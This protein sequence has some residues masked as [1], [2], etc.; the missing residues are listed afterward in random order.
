MSSNHYLKTLSL[1]N[2]DMNDSRIHHV[3]DA[4][5]ENR[6]LQT[7]NLSLN[8]LSGKGMLKFREVFDESDKPLH[9]KSLDLS[10]NEI[11]VSYFY[12]FISL[13]KG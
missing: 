13:I 11:D 8:R 1:A 6:T 7:L 4:L 9:I 5:S 3:V 12:N 10:S 2:C